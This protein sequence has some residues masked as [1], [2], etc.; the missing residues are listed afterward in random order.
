[1]LEHTLAFQEAFLDSTRMHQVWQ[2]VLRSQ[3][4]CLAWRVA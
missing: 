3:G 4:Y 1:M 2:V